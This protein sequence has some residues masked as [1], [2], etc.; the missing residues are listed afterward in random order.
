MA[1]VRD[2]IPRSKYDLER[3]HAAVAAGYPA[4]EPILAELLE[5]MQD[6]NWPTA[7]I[8][9]PFLATIGEPLVPHITAIFQTDDE[10]WKYWIINSLIME[11][12]PLAAAFRPELERLAS[13]PTPR[14]LAE[15]LH[16]VAE[17]VLQAYGWR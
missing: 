2:L 14:E 15:E 6:I 8:L 11:S 16:L 9:Q 1:D 17:E 12:R 4:V 5:W 3:A 10:I 13:Q 7:R